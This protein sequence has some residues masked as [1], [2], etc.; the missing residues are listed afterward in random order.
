MK[1]RVKDFRRVPASEL[2]PNA[3]NFRTHPPEQS[4]ALR[5]MLERIGFA[6]AVVAYE[7]G[8][9]LVLIDGHERR[10]VADPT[11]ELPTL[12]LDVTAA[13][14]EE[15]L[16]TF[17][18]IG[19][20]AGR[21]EEALTELLA[22]LDPD[23]SLASVLEQV[24]H[25]NGHKEGL[26]DPDEVPELPGEP[27]TKVGDL[28]L[29][30][31]HRVL[32]GDATDEVVVGRLWAETPAV[33][34]SDPPYGID[35]IAM[36]RNE[37]MENDGSEAEALAAA[38]KALVLTAQVAVH[39]VCCNWRS[40]PVMLDAMLEAGIEPKSCIVW[41]KGSRVQNLDKFAK[42]HEF[43][44]YAGPFGGEPTRG[45]DVWTIPRDFK[46]DHPTPKPVELVERALL[47]TSRGG[48]ICV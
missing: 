23:E 36:R 28:W 22:R 30:G 3:S 44:L 46:P 35:Y 24:G 39:F 27:E 17:D 45:T 5:T 21:N 31:E 40:L 11:D 38:Q 34:F 14:A 25:L 19:A 33:V 10:E 6:G 9:N 13:E 48:G 4:S 1:D 41:D 18:P 16:A 15:L 2:V 12:I 47:A 42:Q 32:C 37:R 20:M 29:C 26:T 8:D 43:V 7:D